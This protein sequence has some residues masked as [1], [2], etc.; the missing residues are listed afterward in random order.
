M[1]GGVFALLGCWYGGAG[2][3]HFAY[4][5][6]PGVL[7]TLLGALVPRVLKLIYIGWMSLAFI[8][9]ICR[10]DHAADAVFLSDGDAGGADRP[11]RR[12]GFSEPKVDRRTTTLLDQ[13]RPFV[14]RT[15]PELRAT[16]LASLV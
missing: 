2:K 11:T 12:K 15:N 5:L 8:L 16:I 13:A 3:T 6:V 14:V 7:L 4:F 10:L 9:G 1:I